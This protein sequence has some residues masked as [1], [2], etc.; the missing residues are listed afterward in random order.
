MEKDKQSKLTYKGSK[1]SK[2]A[3]VDNKQKFIEKLRD[4]LSI[5]NLKYQYKTNDIVRLI[6]DNSYTQSK[7]LDRKWE[8]GYH[9]GI[10]HAQERI[11]ALEKELEDRKQLLRQIEHQLENTVK[12]ADKHYDDLKKVRSAVDEEMKQIQIKH[13]DNPEWVFLEKIKSLIG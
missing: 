8:D 1:F 2:G 4:E 6:I 11:D 7:E 9:A 10:T 3:M 5:T 13:G 12:R